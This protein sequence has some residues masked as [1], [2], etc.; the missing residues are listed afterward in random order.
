MSQLNLLDELKNIIQ[1]SVITENELL[2]NHT[3]LRIGGAARYFILVKNEKELT[4]LLNFLCGQNI[5]YYILGNGS[6]V[7]ADSE[8]YDGVI[9][10]LD[11]DFNK[12]ELQE[13]DNEGATIKAGAPILLSLVSKCAL[14]NSLTGMEFASGIPGSVGG[15]LVMNAGAYGGEMKQPFLFHP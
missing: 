2:C 1:D 5:K 10:K 6:N 3:T 9:I 13:N 12:F 15:A 14:D 8:G 7:L 11:G 4:D